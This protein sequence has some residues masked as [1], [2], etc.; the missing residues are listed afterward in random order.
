[1]VSTVVFVVLYGDLGVIFAL[2]CIGA[3]QA[4]EKDRYA[5]MTV[6]MLVLMLFSNKVGG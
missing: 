4:W 6:I 2:S 3:K 5:V 1:M